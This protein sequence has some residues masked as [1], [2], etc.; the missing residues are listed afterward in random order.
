MRKLMALTLWVFPLLGWASGAEQD[1]QNEHLC[2]VVQA[3]NSQGQIVKVWQHRF[4]DGTFDLVMSGEQ[5]PLTRL[6]FKGSKDYACHFPAFIIKQGG[7]WG[8]HVTW[9]SSHK[10]GVYYARVDG[11]M[12]VS[13][14]PKKISSLGADLLE[15]SETDGLLVLRYADKQI[16]GSSLSVASSNDE[17]RSW[18][19]PPIHR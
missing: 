6:S 13:S 8:W 5:A 1:S 15:F 4:E 2:R 14:P 7:D 11:Q 19:I 16:S 9:S 12:W 10:A 3:S 18:D 17:G